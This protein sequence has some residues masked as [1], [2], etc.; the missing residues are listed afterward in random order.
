MNKLLAA[1]KQGVTIVT[2]NRRAAHWLRLAYDRRQVESG[3]EAW[4]TPDILP[5]PALMTR[6]WSV[7]PASSA[8]S[9]LPA[10]LS[11]VQERGLWREVISA[12][13]H[14]RSNALALSSLAMKAWSLLHDFNAEPGNDEIGATDDTAA[15]AKWSGVF[16]SS[17]TELGA[18]TAAEMPRRIVRGLLDG[19][20]GAPATLIVVGF[21][22]FTPVQRSV[23]KA[24]EQR[25]TQWSVH[26][27]AGSGNSPVAVEA[28][29]PIRELECAAGWA[30]AQIEGGATSIG[31]VVPDP[32]ASRA[33]IERIFRL[34]LQPEA[35]LPAN[36][37]QPAFH[38][39]LGRRLS[40]WPMISVALTVLRWLAEPLPIAE[41]GLLLRSSFLAG[42][43][44]ERWARARLYAELRRRGGSRLSIRDLAERASWNGK[45]HYCPALSRALLSKAMRVG[46]EEKHTAAEW[47]AAFNDALGVL[48][49][50]A[51]ALNSAEFQCHSRWQELLQDLGSLDRVRPPMDAAQALRTIGEMAKAAAFAPEDSGAPVQ[52]MDAME[53][54]G[55]EFDALWIAGLD[56]ERW[57]PAGHASPLLPLSLQRRYDM[58]NCRP[59]RQAASAARVMQRLQR[60]VTGTGANRAVLSFSAMDGERE[61]RASPV[62]AGFKV[63]ASE[64]ISSP[65][66]SWYSSITAATERYAED[67][68]LPFQQQEPLAASRLFQLVSECPFHAF[69]ELRLHA[70]E[71]NNREE[72]P[73]RMQRGMITHTLMQSLWGELKSHQ[74][75]QS[76]SADELNDAIGRAVNHAL[77]K[78]ADDFPIGDIRE[79]LL[80]IERER[81]Q[82]LTRDWMEI[83]LQRKA[84]AVAE[85][86]QATQQEIG[87]VQVRLRRDRVDQ[88]PDGRTVIIDYK[89]GKVAPH[90]WDGD[91][92]DDPQLPVYAV[93]SGDDR[94]LAAIVF[95]HL[96]A[97][98]MGFR[99]LQS[100]GGI[101]PGAL[102]AG[103]KG[104]PDMQSQVAQWRTVI[105]DLAQKFGAGNAEVD[106]KTPKV[107]RNCD[108]PALCRVAEL[109][110][111]GAA[112]DDGDDHDE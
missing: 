1:A 77:T 105:T 22:E 62:L 55:S 92:P 5:W 90:K 68:S 71:L 75:L 30:R 44:E 31:I 69:A 66:R 50:P 81:L 7:A 9:S 10:V 18:I 89:T 46:S 104:Q 60:S 38:I 64:E 12:D 35:M 23:L 111:F 27:A 45:P 17:L 102:V 86:E 78:H 42:A 19:E 112:S 24:L 3:L 26:E 100:E 97:G 37:L 52:I 101:A 57:P 36:Q 56:A 41:I 48:G 29:D 8:A 96:K 108:L 80:D 106:P 32:E 16:R 6:L 95:A 34:C 47:A 93:T 79:P 94:R 70:R 28:S 54:A 4:R 85:L 99:G 63:L 11:P 87:G 67:S 98:E 109:R 51:G 65:S 74:R 25:G 58:P 107:C 91:R 20:I 13:Q 33:D 21:D 83:E 43:A 73:D 76:L 49:W 61:L 2:S 82:G 84:F 53:A 103:A 59:E 40:D 15:F 110:D 39:S 88:L 72:G 14:A